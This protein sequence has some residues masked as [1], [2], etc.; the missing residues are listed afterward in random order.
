M[1]HGRC[2]CGEVEYNAGGDPNW[3]S[4]CHC[5]Y[6][7]RHSGSAVATFVSFK[8][9]EFRL[10]S[11]AFSNYESSPGVT[12][13]FCIRCGTPMAYRSTAFPGEIHLYIGTL[14]NPQ[15]YPAQVQVFCSQK[16]PWL[17]IDENIPKYETVPQG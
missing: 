11:G 2:L 1:T 10:T 3:S 15:D 13:S 6:C 7:R 5:K 14:D 17:S 4:H 12:R 16:L 8:E 9:G